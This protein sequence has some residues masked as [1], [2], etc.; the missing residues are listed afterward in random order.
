VIESGQCDFTGDLAVPIPALLTM[1]FLGFP[2]SDSLYMAD[3]MHRHGYVSP[4][5]PER[6]EL[7]LEMV[8][9]INGWISTP[10]TFTP[11]KRIGAE[12]PSV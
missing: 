3:L 4:G 8:P 7:M 11:G 2:A 5:T 1:Q 10:A 12:L 9:V 6:T